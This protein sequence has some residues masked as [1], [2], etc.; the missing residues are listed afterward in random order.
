MDKEEIKQEFK[1]QGLPA[2]IKSAQRR[3]AMEVARAA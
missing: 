1:Q 2:E 3:K